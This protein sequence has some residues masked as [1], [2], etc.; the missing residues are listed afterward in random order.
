ML[1]AVAT[2]FERELE[3]TEK[4]IADLRG[5]VAAVPRDVEKGTRLAYRLY[6]RACLTGV[7]SDF[8]AA[9]AAV[10]DVARRAGHQED[11]CLLKANLYFKFHRL[12][13]V[14]LALQQAPAL[15]RRPEG[16]VLQ[17]DIDFQEG[18]YQ[19]AKSAY[20]RAIE[21]DRTWDNL[22]RLAHFQFKMGKISEADDLYA[23]AEDELTAKEM[24]SF[25]WVELQRGLLPLSRGR[26]ENAL[27]HYR[28]AEA[29]YSGYWLIDEHMAE[30][31]GAQGK[32]PEAAALYEHVVARVPK[33]E[34]QQALGELYELM[35]QPDKAELWHS[36]ALET[37]LHSV[38][39]GGVHYWH[40][41]VDF[42]ADVREDGAAAVAW[43][44]KDLTLRENFATQAALA[45]ALWRDDQ[46][47]DA[48]AFMDRAL[49]SGVVDARLFQ[50]AGK[51]YLSAGQ[52]DKGESLLRQAQEINPHVDVFH[53]HR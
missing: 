17:A 45:W 14:K 9:E 18:R 30:L 13:D 23:Q 49:A 48:A 33:P 19:E 16:K 42:F 53:V 35:E 5:S 4:D 37:Y 32:Y 29:A 27:A 2:D 38:D 39:E 10:D 51:I 43:A 25:A 1:T 28:R 8:S 46:S 7:L 3:R 6:H 44:R 50:S 31:L 26:Y 21:E 36:R 20:E 41:L 15:L 24:R 11:L 12:P 22:A 52:V 47:T 40:H 34:L